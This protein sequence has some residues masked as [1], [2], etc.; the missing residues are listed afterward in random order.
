MFQG[1]AALES[2]IAY[3]IKMTDFG[4]TPFEGWLFLFS[5]IIVLLYDIYVV[6]FVWLS[7]LQCYRACRY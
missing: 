2:V 6:N 5:L 4:T 7:L 1:L 3:Y